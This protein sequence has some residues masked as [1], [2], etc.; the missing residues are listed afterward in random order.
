MV[1]ISTN[2]AQTMVRATTDVVNKA[3]SKLI[4][5]EKGSAENFQTLS[6]VNANIRC[7][8]D[9][10]AVQTSQGDVTLKTVAALTGNTNFSN[11][12]KDA[13]TD[14]FDQA[15][16]EKK[17]FVANVTSALGFGVT[18]N[19]TKNDK[20]IKKNLTNYFEN[21]QMQDIILK[22]SST[23]KQDFTDAKL[24]I[25]KDCNFS[26]DNMQK[27]Y[28]ETFAKNVVN[29]VLTNVG[30]TN[31]KTAIY[32]KGGTSKTSSTILIII[33][34]LIVLSALGMMYKYAQDNPN[35]VK[36]AARVK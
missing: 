4:I 9:F 8:G 29:Q 35:V 32:Q 19:V 1:N 16:P 30:V 2:V 26:Q 24:D 27:L 7:G 11:D 34:A 25:G 3:V 5:D 18:T 12:I 17:G 10:N 31:A 15:G 28:N 22:A 20:E 14:S 36:A 21:N 23:Q 6:F 13:V 33:I